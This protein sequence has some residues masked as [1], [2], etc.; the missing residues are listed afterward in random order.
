MSKH[1]FW[2]ALIFT[3]IVFGSGLTIGFFLEGVQSD[4]IYSRL[5]SSELDLLDDQLTQQIIK[6]YNVSCTQSRKSLFEFADRIYNEAT[7]LEEIDGT[8]RIRDLTVLHKRY[9]LLRTLLL[10]ESKNLKTRCGNDFHVFTYFYL[11]NS[12]DVEIS[13]KQNYFSRVLFDLKEIH[14]D[15]VLLV[16]I[17]SDT[18]LVSVDALINALEIR[19]YPSIVIDDSEI[20]TDNIALDELEKKLVFLSP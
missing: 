2:R 17:A 16:P 14:P 8:G 6:D 9:D 5:I 19:T 11:Y 4:N 13:S 10:K 7:E 12:L 1:A 3:L 18:N 20:I 15:S